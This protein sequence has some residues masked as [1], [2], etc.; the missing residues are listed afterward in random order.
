MSEQHVAVESNEVALSNVG[1]DGDGDEIEAGA[2]TAAPGD[3]VDSNGKGTE[4]DEPK[5]DEPKKDDLEEELIGYFDDST[6]QFLF[7]SKVHESDKDVNWFDMA[8]AATVWCS[9]VGLYNY[10][11]NKSKEAFDE[12]FVPVAVKYDECTEWAVD[13]LLNPSSLDYLYCIAGDNKHSSFD[14]I[15]ALLMFTWF[16]S[17]DIVGGLV[18][19]KK[20]FQNRRKGLVAVGFALLVEVFFGF[21]CCSWMAQSS[22][23]TGGI[24]E[25]VLTAV[26]VAFIHD[27]DEAVRSVYAFVWQSKYVLLTMAALIAGPILLNI[28]IQLFADTESEETVWDE[29]QNYWSTTTPSPSM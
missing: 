4:S 8:V 10:L 18:L 5:K 1:G 19:M 13:G 3:D 27:L 25:A 28:P 11:W 17:R 16:V 15:P 9:Q 24:D 22:L 23:L 21:G 20:G 26:G 29:N 14:A 6:I 2:T 7:V 12:N